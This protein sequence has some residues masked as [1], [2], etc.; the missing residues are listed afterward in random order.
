[1]VLILEQHEVLATRRGRIM[2]L[3][4]AY[5]VDGDNRDRDVIVNASYGGILPARFIGRYRPRAVISVDCCGGPQGYAISGMYYLEALGIPCAMADVM[6]VLLGDSRDMYENGRISF[7]NQLARDCGVVRG[8]SVKH[9]ARM[10][11]DIDPQPKAPDEITNRTVISETP[12]GRQIV[13]LDSIAFGIPE[14]DHRN[15]LVSGG[16]TALRAVHNMLRTRPFGFIASDGCMG[17]DRSGIQ[18]M[19][20]VEAHD[21]AVACV[22]GRTARMGDGLSTYHDGTISAANALAAAAGVRK[23]MRTPEAAALLLKRSA[24]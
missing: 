23:G 24:S 12:G 13:C 5:D 18:G 17:R 14:I 9:A 7:M 19:L 6:T 16:H 8:M 4:A 11:L 21:L 15:V 1:M 22:D 20:A 10:L 2:A 3:D